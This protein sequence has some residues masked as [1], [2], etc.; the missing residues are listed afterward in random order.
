MTTE[1]A[2]VILAAGRGSRLG[3]AVPKPLTVLSD[4]RTIL[5]QQLENIVAIF[6]EAAL[7]RTFVVVG[8]RSEEIV[9]K[10]PRGVRPIYNEDWDGSNTSKSVMRALRATTRYSGAIWMNGDVVFSPLVLGRALPF[11]EA[12]KSFMAVVAGKTSDEEMKYSLNADG[13]ITTVAKDNAK[14]LGEAVG[15]NFVAPDIR[16][17]FM[18]ELGR[19]PAQAYFEAGIERTIQRGA[20]WLPMPV[21]DLYA[22]EIDFAE[23]LVR[24]NR[25][26]DELSGPSSLS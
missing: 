17:V 11:V 8:Y 7:R 21:N 26:L 6:G 12:G 5:Q 24:A 13:V 2:I 16:D 15:I 14:G 1:P 20:E 19:V 9:E 22:M 10:L 18:Y 25:M 4:G 23:D 3:G